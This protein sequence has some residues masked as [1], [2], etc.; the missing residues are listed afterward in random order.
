MKLSFPKSKR[1]INN[2]QFKDILANGRRVRDKI[3]TIYIAPNDCGYS[4]LGISISSSCGIAVERNHIKRLLRE[5]FRLN[6]DKI[7]AGLDI[8]VLLSGRLR[9]SRFTYEQLSSS[10]LELFAAGL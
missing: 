7:P 8:I 5:S 6:Q 9:Q 1:I 3:L 4:R 2:R 10:F